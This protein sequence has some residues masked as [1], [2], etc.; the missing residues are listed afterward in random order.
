MQKNGISTLFSFILSLSQRNSNLNFAWLQM[1]ELVSW[2]SKMTTKECFDHFFLDSF[3]SLS[4]IWPCL[5]QLR[6][7][8]PELI[9]RW[10]KVEF[11][12]EQKHRE[13]GITEE[14][15]ESEIYF[16]C[17]SN[18]LDLGISMVLKTLQT[19]FLSTLLHAVSLLWGRERDFIQEKESWRQRPILEMSLFVSLKAKDVVR[20]GIPLT[21]LFLT[22]LLFHDIFLP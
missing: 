19:C 15:T 17:Y 22:F 21:F 8:M 16:F 13:L 11:V 18:D 20:E 6:N 7:Q 2:N 1:Q 10:L 4:S 12:S 14:L 5:W 3:P 9:G